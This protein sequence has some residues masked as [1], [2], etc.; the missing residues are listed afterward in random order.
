MTSARTALDSKPTFL[1]IG[2]LKDRAPR[3]TLRAL[4]TGGHVTPIATI[5]LSISATDDFGLAA[6]RLKTDRTASPDDKSPPVTQSASQVLPLAL[7]KDR[8][9]L[10][11][12]ARHEV[13]LQ[14]DPPK[15]G[16]LIRFVAEADDRCAHGVQTGRSSALQ[17]QVVSPDE[18]FYEILIRQRV[19]RAKF[20]AAL[21]AIEKQTP[22][23]AG[24]PKSEDF[25]KVMRVHHSAARQL[26]QIAGRV[27]DTL[28]EMKLNQVGS[29]KSHRLL[30]QA[31]IDPMKALTAG[32]MSQVRTVLQSLAGA[33]SSAG[34]TEAEARRLHDE[35]V[36]TMKNILDQMSQWESF[37]DVVNQVAEVIKMQQK[38]L[39]ETE[40]ARE[41][42]TR[43]VFDDK[44]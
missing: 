16:T 22:V 24:Q 20:L 19:E 35:V 38:V 14:A 4:G 9:L 1:S 15:I 2:L 33:A 43:E 39:K 34:A 12:Q 21:E 44:P 3:V 29:P 10:D 23:L 28:Q 25:L 11:H 30:Q 18:L 40:K 7:E 42:R 27:A 8:P 36:T 37:V 41:T 26:D 13:V 6:L 5:P 31:V 32:P 17:V